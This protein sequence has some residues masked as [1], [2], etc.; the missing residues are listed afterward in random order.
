MQNRHLLPPN[1]KKKKKNSHATWSVEIKWLYGNSQSESYYNVAGG[2][3]YG[4][5][6]DCVVF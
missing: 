3:V 5:D 1:L 2:Q 4:R 6:R